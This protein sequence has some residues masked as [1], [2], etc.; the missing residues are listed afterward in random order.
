VKPGSKRRLPARIAP[1]SISA[2]GSQDEP[3][4]ECR[5]GQPQPRHP[6]HRLGLAALDAHRKIGGGL[7]ELDPNLL[8][9]FGQA[10]FRFG[11]LG[12]GG[13][14][15]QIGIA[16]GQGLEGLRDDPRPGL[17]VRSA[18]QLL[19]EIDDRGVHERSL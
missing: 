5:L 3:G 7:P 14:L 18:G 17:V 15:G 8:D 12:A 16:L 11:Q 9:R 19:V 6:A 13:R 1:L 2:G 4:D 10:K